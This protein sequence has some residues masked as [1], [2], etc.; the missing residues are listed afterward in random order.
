[1]VNVG[2]GLRGRRRWVHVSIEGG[3][4]KDKGRSQR[5]HNGNNYDGLRGGGALHFLNKESGKGKGVVERSEG[6]GKKPKGWGGQG[7]KLVP[8]SQGGKGGN[9]RWGA[10]GRRRSKE[11]L[12]QGN[13]GW[14]GRGEKTSSKQRKKNRYGHIQ[15]GKTEK[16]KF[17][18]LSVQW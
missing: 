1:V 2:G 5:P 11:S 8:P 4:E 17:G 9:N 13:S 18:R 7:R 15:R 3:T 12:K 6:G 10:S 14:G 16:K